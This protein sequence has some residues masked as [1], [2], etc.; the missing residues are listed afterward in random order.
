MAHDEHELPAWVR[1]LAQGPLNDKMTPAEQQAAYAELLPALLESYGVEN[2]LDGWRDT[3]IN[4]AIEYHH[5]FKVQKTRRLPVSGR[6]ISDQRWFCRNQVLAKVRVLKAMAKNKGTSP[7]R[8]HA[9]AARQV[10]VQLA[11]VERR[12]RQRLRGKDAS[13]ILKTPSAKTLQNLLSQKIPLSNTLTRDDY[14]FQAR[15]AAHKAARKLPK[16]DHPGYTNL[17]L[18]LAGYR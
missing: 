11:A 9:E 6:P 1:I 17:P 2:T 13:H 16:P 4:L 18:I 10:H 3:A 7:T 5:A 15:Q 8:L 14:L 12:A